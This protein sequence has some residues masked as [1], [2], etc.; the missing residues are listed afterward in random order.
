MDTSNTK[1]A[2]P[3]K[4]QTDGNE[5]HT[6]PPRWVAS[7]GTGLS[8]SQSS[9]RKFYMI[10]G[11]WAVLLGMAV[12]AGL[13]SPGRQDVLPTP[14]TGNAF[15]VEPDSA[16]EP[17]AETATVRLLAEP[18][19][20]MPHSFR[21]AQTNCII[22][23]EALQPVTRVLARGERPLRVLHIGDSHVAGKNFPLAVKEELC[24]CLGEASQADEGSGVWFSYIGKNG[25]TTQTFLTESYLGSFAAKKPDLIILSLGTNE[26]HGMGYRE[27]LH[28]RQLEA[29]MKKLRQ[30]CPEAVVLLTTPPGD[31]LTSSYVDYRKMA[32]SK[33]K[34]R[35]VHYA[36]RPNP[37]SS[38]CASCLTDYAASNGLPCWD[39][40]TICG[41]EG[42]AQRNWVAGHYMRPDRVHFEP[43]GYRLQGRLLAEALLRALQPAT[44]A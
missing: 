19:N 39:L 38:R 2:K 1:S 36:K 4:P 16:A 26:A 33:R 42:A 18:G 22:R 7:S 9:S 25:A 6:L 44:P 43:E 13:V 23:P 8:H 12:A 41:G 40:F 17:L 20:S 35:Q 5:S 15:V 29:F 27:D 31:Y 30:A 24:R 21:N 3:T 28:Q 37:M 34:V 14:A 11:G 10:V 32:R